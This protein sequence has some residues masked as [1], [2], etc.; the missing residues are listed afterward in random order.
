MS[1]FI[2]YSFTAGAVSTVNPCGF[3]LLP[4]WFSRQLVAFQ[5]RPKPERML[6]ATVAGALVS[7]GFVLVFLLASAVLASSAMALGSALPYI[8]VSLGVALAVVGLSWL[9]D[10]RLPGVPVVRKCRTINMRYGAF[11]FGLSYGL[12]S[13]SCTLPIFMSIAGISFLAGNDISPGGIV[14]FLAGATSVLTLTSVLAMTTGSGLESLIRNRIG[15]LRRVSGALTLV[16]GL[17]VVLYWGRLFIT[18]S[19]WADTIANRVAIWAANAGAVLSSN[20]V[21][22][23]LGGATLASIAIGWG[24]FRFAPTDASGVGGPPDGKG[25]LLKKP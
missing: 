3:A 14:A 5:D 12:V 15:L 7:S 10:L 23:I 1:A 24:I 2:I 13:I 19:S 25:K 22:A 11:G 16:A 18:G 6:R 9:F 8:G 21:L 17:Y 20:T 4:V